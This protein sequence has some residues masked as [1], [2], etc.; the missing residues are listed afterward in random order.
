MYNGH[1]DLHTLLCK[2]LQ[3]HAG[4]RLNPPPPPPP[5]SFRDFFK[6]KLPRD[7]RTLF[8]DNFG[9]LAKKHLNFLASFPRK[10]L[11]ALNR[12]SHEV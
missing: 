11:S 3:F 6:G 9:I 8:Y 2:E 7:S 10:S 12:Q 1:I 4:T 5:T